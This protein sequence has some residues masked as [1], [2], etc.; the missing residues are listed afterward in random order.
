MTL[1]STTCQVRKAMNESHF[2]DEPALLGQWTCSEGSGT[3]VFDSSTKGNH[4]TLEG[5]VVRVQCDRDFVPPIMTASEKHVDSQ[6]SGMPLA[7]PHLTMAWLTTLPMLHLLQYLQLREWKMLFEKREKR[8][9][10][11]G[12]MLMATPEIRNIARRLGLLDLV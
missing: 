3:Q 8:Q 12:D 7:A 5:N 2:V 11:R 4:G 9:P 1:S 6:A 10:T